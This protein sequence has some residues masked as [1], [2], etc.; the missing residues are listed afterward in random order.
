MPIQHDIRKILVRSVVHRGIEYGLSVVTVGDTDVTIE[1]F[2]HET[3]ATVFY[4]GRLRIV[5]RDNDGTTHWHQPGEKPVII[6]E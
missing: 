1:P 6:E 3:A 4:P 5:A 2:V